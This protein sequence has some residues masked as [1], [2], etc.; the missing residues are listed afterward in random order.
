MIDPAP[1]PQPHRRRPRYAGKYP[2]KFEDKYKELDP[3]RDPETIKKVLASGK[4]P[5]GTHRPIMVAEA[6]EILA[7]QPGDIAVDCTLGYGGHAEE[8]L[9]RIAPGGRLLGLDAD[10]IELP[11]TEARLRAE[12]F[13]TDVFTAY[14]LSLIHI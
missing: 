10:P 6:I 8:I 1:E 9:R 14:R 2:R 4:T 12:G 11:K 7:P 3:A 13:G 5:A